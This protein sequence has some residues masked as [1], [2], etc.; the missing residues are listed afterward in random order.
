M[1]SKYIKLFKLK[2]G[3]LLMNGVQI[4]NRR[5]FEDRAAYQFL[6][7]WKWEWLVTL[8]FP[9]EYNRASSNRL[10]LKLIKS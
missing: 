7:R 1:Y 10:M 5:R 4:S 8:T 2:K 9:P 6:Q 3:G